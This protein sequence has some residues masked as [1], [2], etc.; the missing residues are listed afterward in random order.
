MS[1]T[2]NLAAASAL[3]RTFV[4][5]G[6]RHAVVSPG[7]RSTPLTLALHRQDIQRSVRVH[8][9]LDERVAGFVAL[10]LARSSGLPA[11]LVCTSGS[12]GANYLP[13]V[14]EAAESR[15]PL[16]ALTADRPARL[17][18]CGAPQTTAQ[19]RLLD[20]H[21]RWSAT[22]PLPS[23]DLEPRP[24]R[25]A[26]LTA[27]DRCLRGPAGP[28][29]LNVP[30][31]EPLWAPDAE[32]ASST[33]EAPP[34][35]IAGRP[36]AGLGADGERAL[37]AWLAGGERGLIVC[38][39]RR[40][41]RDSGLGPIIDR[42]SSKL[43]WPVVA[44]AASG[45]RFGAGGGPANLISS[46]DAMLRH[47]GFAASVRPDRILRFGA[48]PTSKPVA[49]WLA[50]QTRATTALV[51]PDGVWLDPEHRA[52]LLVAADPGALESVLVDANPP[53][54]PSWLARW[55]RADHVSQAAIAAACAE[56]WW[57]GALARTVCSRLP[58]SA[59]LHVASSMPIRDVDSFAAPSPRHL[60]VHANRG[61][62]GIDGTLS[63][64][65][66]I[67][68]EKPS[69]PTCVLIGDLAFQH[70]AGGLLAAGA[71][72]VRMTVV[73]VDNGGGGIFGFLPIASHPT[74]FEPLFV[75]PHP[76]DLGALAASAGARVAHVSDTAQLAA[77]L[78]L[79]LE[80]PGLGVVIATT[81]PDENLAR[82]AL[83]W[84][85]VARALEA[86]GLIS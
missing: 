80:R 75:T 58:E 55:R 71:L 13:A 16:I 70:D 74:A 72:G 61:V 5:G 38:G 20:S 40:G 10:G 24:F 15:L 27:L 65:L 22:L 81:R 18:H 6:V 85:A 56:G 3:V 77:A 35:R 1:A 12:A 34:Q 73:V 39:P 82:H 78:A 50:A 54:D 67:A 36:T 48:A 30:F 66:G 33:N 57:E 41:P 69:R 31:A 26:A 84:R 51:D 23:P 49:T 4:A 60:E 2:A 76:T 25:S 21:T 62:N 8:V 28:V 29:H 64:A 43:G 42:I 44:D 59:A 47:A 19:H 86:A 68:L 9:V 7:S 83:A 79:D 52:T 32:A 63:T 14:V 45:V 53:A 17:H 46:A 37:R 11:L